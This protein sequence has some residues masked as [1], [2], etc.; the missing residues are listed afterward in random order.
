MKEH[1]NKEFA[2]GF[3]TIK[4]S[5]LKQKGVLVVIRFQE[6]SEVKMIDLGVINVEGR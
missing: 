5:L 1:K 6:K 2:I 3:P 4:P